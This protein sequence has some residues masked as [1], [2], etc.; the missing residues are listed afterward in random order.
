MQSL[1]RAM[2]RTPPVSQS[3]YQK[4]L[5]AHPPKSAPVRLAKKDMRSSE[6]SQTHAKVREILRSPVLWKEYQSKSFQQHIKRQQQARALVAQ[7]TLAAETAAAAHYKRAQ[8]ALQ[9]HR[10]GT[11]AV[12]Q[13][14]PPDL[15]RRKTV[16]SA[17]YLK[18]FWQGRRRGLEPPRVTGTS[19]SPS[20]APGQSDSGA[21]SLDANSLLCGVYVYGKRRLG[22][23]Y[24]TCATLEQLIARVCVRFGIASVLNV[25]R[26]RAVAAPT[27]VRTGDRRARR[28][29]GKTFQRVTAFE[30]VR[31][32]DRLCVTQDAYEDMAILCEWIQQRQVRVYRMASQMQATN[33]A[34]QQRLS[35]KQAGVDQVAPLKAPVLDSTVRSASSGSSSVLWDSNGRSVAIKKQLRV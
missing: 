5:R 24:F 20:V 28:A 15:G 4:L 19:A 26:E 25:Y 34:T 8:Y 23:A 32:G 6:R 29:A 30:Q 16:Y 12:A 1:V 17:T 10:N 13:Q 7:E 27:L 3:K 18:H 9:L 35:T 21:P 2:G 33:G 22:L 14:A 11:A 31:D